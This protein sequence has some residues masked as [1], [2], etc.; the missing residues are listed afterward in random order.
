MSNEHGRDRRL[1][2]PS[3]SDGPGPSV[4]WFSP[5]TSRGES[6]VQNLQPV[7]WYWETRER[8]VQHALPGV[9]VWVARRARAASSGP[10]GGRGGGPWSRARPPLSGRSAG[11]SPRRSAHTARPS[12]ARG[13]PR[14]G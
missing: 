14:S 9:S 2:C 3:V 1:F 12:P 11:G 6:D 5:H 7:K 10:R 13:T 4:H 8:T